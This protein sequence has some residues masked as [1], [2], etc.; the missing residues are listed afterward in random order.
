MTPWKWALNKHVPFH[1][2]PEP[3]ITANQLQDFQ[4][5]LNDYKDQL[6]CSLWLEIKP[7]NKEGLDQCLIIE[8][9][10]RIQ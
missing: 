2:Q 7:L 8:Y 1:T 9:N 5:N 3:I 6:N 4:N 10:L